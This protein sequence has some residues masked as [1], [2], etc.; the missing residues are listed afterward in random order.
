MNK[1][2][3]SPLPMFFHKSLRMKAMIF[4]AGLGT[5]LRPYTNDKPKALIEVGGEPLLGIA[6]RRLAA[7]GCREVVINVH[8]F[9][10][11]VMDFLEKNTPSGIQIH[12]SDERKRL[13]DTGGGLKKA[14][15]LL[16]GDAPFLVCN[17]DILTNLDLAAF[18][19]RHCKSKALATLAVRQ[20][21]TSRY[22][23][24][25]EKMCLKGWQNSKTGDV[26]YVSGVSSVEPL[27]A[28]AFSGV[29]AISPEIFKWMPEEEVF[30]IIDVYLAA[31]GKNLVAGYPHDEDVWMDVGSPRSLE[32]AEKQQI[33]KVL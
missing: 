4:A 12:I 26:V 31:A 25:D 21:T 18:Y 9:A 3:F 30:S 20:R 32:E 17:V 23:L 27:E 29:H 13:L 15:P 10:E 16:D 8:H 2:F 22:F 5:R 19:A 14:A 7:A 24:F 33:I 28:W 6:L 11:Q 1:F